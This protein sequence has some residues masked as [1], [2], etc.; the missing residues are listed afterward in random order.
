MS[1]LALFAPF[2]FR[3]NQSLRPRVWFK[4]QRRQ[5]AGTYPPLDCIHSYTEQDANLWPWKGLTTQ[6][7]Y[8]TQMSSSLRISGLKSRYE[9]A[10]QIA[11]QHRRALRKRLGSVEKASTCC[12]HHIH[13]DHMIKIQKEYNLSLAPNRTQY[14]QIYNFNPPLVNFSELFLAGVSR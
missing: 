2:D 8:L 7:Y 10:L 5:R 13:N 9:T 6:R 1:P 3:P 11:P 14:I 12:Y 4:V